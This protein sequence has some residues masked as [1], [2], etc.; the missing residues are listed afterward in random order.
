MAATHNDPA[1]ADENNSPVGIVCGGG[2]LPFAVAAAVLRRGR[3]VFLLPI[4]GW[5][6]ADRVAA[7]PHAW[8]KLGQF[9]R[10]QRLA[11][12]AGCSDVVCIG[13]LRRPLLRSMKLDW[14]TIRLLPRLYRLYRGGDDHLLSGVGR[15]VEEHGFHLL[16]AHEVAPEILVPEGVL[17]RRSP[18][19]VQLADA[20]RGF[21]LLEVVGSFDVGQAAVVCDN[22]IL[23]IEGPEGTDAML[24]RV[25]ELRRTGRIRFA[26]GAGV[27]VKAS[28]PGQ[29]RRLDLPA[30]GPTT[31][32]GVSE[33]G[34]AGIALRADEVL[35]AE[36]EALVAA[37]DEAGLF[38]L[39]VSPN[40]TPHA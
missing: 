33:A 2:A 40:A 5:A 36:S 16:G 3:P 20:R 23:A 35:M 12:N 4:E 28:K 17:S 21:A 30:I 24:K 39:G 13:T 1:A 15:L 37:A 22:R 11:R 25:A 34:L 32:A 31:V 27:L 6:D 8:M 7:Y 29:E 9:G 10:A 18:S 19:P 26:N 14:T 38:L